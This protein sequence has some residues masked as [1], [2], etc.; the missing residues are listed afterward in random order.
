MATLIDQHVY[1]E[2]VNY[3]AEKPR[4]KDSFKKLLKSIVKAAM[5]S[6]KGV[7]PNVIQDRLEENI[8]LIK[9][10]KKEVTCHLK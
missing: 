5:D 3:A 6:G 2:M 7:D 10:E 8:E 4:Y 1:Q 9:T